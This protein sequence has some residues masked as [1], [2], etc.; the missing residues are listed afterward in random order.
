MFVSENR[1]MLST[2]P[3]AINADS[4]VVSC[5]AWAAK[6]EIIILTEYTCR[7]SVQKYYTI[8]IHLIEAKAACSA[9][10]QFTETIFNYTYKIYKY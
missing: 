4:G 1:D 8:P 7:Q 6:R 2:G 9:S 3:W 5:V 10:T